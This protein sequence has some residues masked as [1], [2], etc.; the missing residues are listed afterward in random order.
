MRSWRDPSRSQRQHSPRKLSSAR[1]LTNEGGNRQPLMV[2]GGEWMRCS[3]RGDTCRRGLSRGAG[4]DAF[5]YC[6][7]AVALSSS[8]NF[9]VF[10]TRSL[11]P[12]PA[13]GSYSHGVLLLFCCP[14]SSPG[15]AAASP[16][17]LCKAK[18]EAFSWFSSFFPVWVMNVLGIVID[19]VATPSFSL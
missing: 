5:S 19:L 16:L 15:K 7:W 9:M 4:E 17:T 6:C 13:L 3:W 11:S 8:V 10:L 2:L 18:K 12:L 1:P 14:K